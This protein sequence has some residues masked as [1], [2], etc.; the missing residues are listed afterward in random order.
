MEHLLDNHK[1]HP[2]QCKNNKKLYRDKGVLEFERKSVE[3][4]TMRGE[5]LSGGK[6]TAKQR[7]V[8]KDI[9]KYEDR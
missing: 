8:P 6:V 4:K 2:D 9:N 7:V 3:T 1:N 5:S